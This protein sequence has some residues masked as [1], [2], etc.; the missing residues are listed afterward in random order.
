MRAVGIALLLL[1]AGVACGSA[2]A[3]SPG[4]RDESRSR[5]TLGIVSLDP[6]TVR[7]REFVAGERIKLLLGTPPRTKS[8]RADARGRFTVRFRVGAG[9]CSGVVVQA[10]GSR[11]SRALVDVGAPTCSPLG[12]PPGGGDSPPG[13][14]P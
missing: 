6:L 9:R 8:A 12:S 10:F 1:L 4:E 5:P 3:S 2:G 14:R 13:E 7:G 11:G